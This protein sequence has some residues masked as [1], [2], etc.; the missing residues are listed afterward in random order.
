MAACPPLL[1]Q[2]VLGPAS[3]GPSCAQDWHLL[4]PWWLQKVHSVFAARPWGLG[5]PP[6]TSLP[7]CRSVGP[8]PLKAPDGP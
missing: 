8:S 6:P 2:S 7:V 4:L 5:R 3:P 1:S